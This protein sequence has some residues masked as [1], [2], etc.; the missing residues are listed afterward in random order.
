MP[1]PLKQFSDT[2]LAAELKSRG[3]LNEQ[4]LVK[5]AVYEIGV[6]ILPIACADI[7]LVNQNHQI[8]TIIRA[9]GPEAGKLALTGGRIKR[10]QKVIDAISRH[11]KN[12]LNITNWKFYSGNS[13]QFP[14]FVQQY[15]QKSFAEKNYGYDPTK[16]AIALTFLVE[17]SEEP[18]PKN[19]ANKFQWI[20]ESEIPEITAYN[21]TV[22]MKQA[23]DFLKSS[24]V[25]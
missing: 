20:S 2:E 8:G 1:Y 5:D 13:E 10:D 16:H 12:D 9:T 4:G 21:H 14:F 7:V 3:Y 11:L 25:K 17:T 22:A 23:F 24:E 15:F 19:E 18:K 6:D